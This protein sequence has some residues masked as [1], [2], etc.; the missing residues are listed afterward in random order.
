VERKHGWIGRVRWKDGGGSEGELGVR[1][2]EGSGK[3]NVIVNFVA[4]SS[5]WTHLVCSLT[6]TIE[7]TSVAR[8]LRSLAL[9][10]S[11]LAN[12]G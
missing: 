6:R 10:D 9:L 5:H 3:R 8:S 4:H 7:R 2:E 1:C 11:L 12:I